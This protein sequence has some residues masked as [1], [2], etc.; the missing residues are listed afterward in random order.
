MFILSFT[1]NWS[2]HKSQEA[3]IAYVMQLSRRGCYARLKRPNISRCVAVLAAQ[4]AIREQQGTPGTEQ[5]F[6]LL[7]SLSMEMLF[8]CV[9]YMYALQNITSIRGLTQS[10]ASSGKEG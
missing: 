5:S 7:S 10:F 1:R 2:L 4:E 3:S 8:E 9:P 6:E